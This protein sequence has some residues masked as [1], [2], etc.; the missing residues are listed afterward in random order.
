MM[1]ATQ[2]FFAVSVLTTFLTSAAFPAF[3]Q[4]VPGYGSALPSSSRPDIV[5]RQNRIQTERPEVG[6]AP[7]INAPVRDGKKTGSGPSFVLNNIKIEDSTTFSE[8]ELKTV[9]ADKIGTSIAL[10]ELN[11]IADDITA[12]YRNKGYILTRAVVPPQRAEKGVIRIRIV[13]GFVNEVK[14]QGDISSEN[15][16]LIKE[17]AEK[18]R[19][20]KPLNAATLERYLLL[21]EDLPGVEARAVLQPAAKTP[22]A[23]D[24][25]ITIKR[26]AFDFG[27]SL[28]NRGSRFIGQEQG[29]L[30]A[31]A[32]NAMGLDE[33]TQLR[34]SGTPFD[35]NE[36]RFIEVRQEHQLGNEGTTLVASANRSLTHPGYTLTPFNIKGQSTALN[37]GVNHP[38]IRSRR[39]NWFVSTDFTARDVD[40]NALGSDLFHDRTRVVS[41]GTSYDFVDRLSAINRAEVRFGKGL[42]FG[43]GTDGQAKSRANGTN[44]FEKFVGKVTRIQPIDG[45][46]SV[47]GAV[48]GQYAFQPLL[49]SEEFVAGG[50][51]FGTA[52]DP[53]EITGDSG[54]ATRIEL[55][56]NQAVES[57]FLTQYQVYGFYDIGSVWNRGVTLAS[58]SKRDSLSSTGAGVR[59]NAQ[60]ALSGSLEAALPLTRDVAALGTDGKSPR[61]FFGLQYRY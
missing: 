20:A 22:G 41:V 18:I 54:V 9:Y 46:W 8:D 7:L 17:Y 53:A 42:S 34:V 2:R 11:S 50:P 24:V 60:S 33:E 57:R 15:A 14:L 47:F 31:T 30:T 4:V 27:A 39:D 13:E 6:G 1:Y 40:V 56:N 5:E 10:D 49:A 26:K 25:I 58:D 3:S 59:F 43:T 38:V 44:D 16:S 21:M 35:G 28:D 61:L 32:N 19:G 37:I 36:L 48:N 29:A 55:Q 52:Y 23:S 51:E 12:Y 45:P